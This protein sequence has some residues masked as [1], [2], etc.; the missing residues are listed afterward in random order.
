MLTPTLTIRLTTPLRS[1]KPCELQITHKVKYFLE[2]NLLYLFRK[3]LEIILK[4]LHNVSVSSQKT[5][6][7]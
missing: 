5:D 7:N 4:V 2:V 3:D 1:F 6:Y